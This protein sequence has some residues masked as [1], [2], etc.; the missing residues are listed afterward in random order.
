MPKTKGPLFSLAAHGS[1]KKTLTYSSRKNGQKMRNYSK[2]NRTPTGKQRARRRL[3]EFILA[4]WQGMEAAEK[5]TW[6]ENVE[7]KKLQITGYQYFLKECHRDI[8]TYHG[9]KDYYDF[10]TIEGIRLYSLT[11]RNSYMTRKSQAPAPLPYNVQG[12][13]RKMDKALRFELN[14][15]YLE[16]TGSSWKDLGTK[17][18]FVEMWVRPEGQGGETELLQYRSFGP[19][20]GVFLKVSPTFIM[21]RLFDGIGGNTLQS[22]INIRDQ[23]WHCLQF[24]VNRSGTMRILVDGKEPTPGLDITALTGSLTNPGT[25]FINTKGGTYYGEIDEVALYWRLPTDEELARRYFFGRK[26]QKK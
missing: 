18:F 1:I 15:S 10:N 16:N 4:Q 7:A 19:N 21:L 24:V 12:A 9:L 13:T 2:P 17:D 22:I 26:N 5:A 25:L 23:K 6:Q 14:T 8:A 11:D 3:V 20:T